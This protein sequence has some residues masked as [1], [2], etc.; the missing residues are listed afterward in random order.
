MKVSINPKFCQLLFM[1]NLSRWHYSAIPAFAEYWLSIPQKLTERETLAI[2]RWRDLETNNQKN[3]TIFI[4]EKYL[5]GRL[6]KKQQLEI[7]HCLSV[8]RERFKFHFNK[9][10]SNMRVVADYLSRVPLKEIIKKTS[11][12]YGCNVDAPRIYLTL[13]RNANREAGGM[14]LDDKVI[15]QFGDFKLHGNNEEMLSILFHELTHDCSVRKLLPSKIDIKLPSGFTG[16][17]KDYIDEVIHQALWGQLGVLS[18]E[19]FNL[20]D[21]EM[22]KRKN[23]LIEQRPEPPKS[24][25]EDS[26]HI[27]RIIKLE[28]EKNPKW[29]ITKQNVLNLLKLVGPKQGHC[30]DSAGQKFRYLLR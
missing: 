27:G 30:S 2:S 13:S 24:L 1:H 22:L 7:T 15:L 14:L 3:E 25:A 8:L 9:Q 17:V 12:I 18:Q 11:A 29:Q 6:S 5:S 16:N 20:S 26:Y 28:R 19:Y 10:F 4:F 21:K 23:K